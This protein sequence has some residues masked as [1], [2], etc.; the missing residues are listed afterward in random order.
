MESKCLEEFRFMQ[1]YDQDC[2]DTWRRKDTE[3]R[4]KTQKNVAISYLSLDGQHFPLT[5]LSIR[6]YSWPCV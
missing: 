5:I 6:R 1:C 3:F 2:L 4:H